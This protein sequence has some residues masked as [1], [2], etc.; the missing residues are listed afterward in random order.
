MVS[1]IRTWLSL[2]FTLKA[3]LILS[4]TALLL[5]FVAVSAFNRSQMN[6]IHQQVLHQ[7]AEMNKQRLALELKIK[8]NEIDAVKSGYIISKDEKLIG[9]FEQK[10]ADFYTLV[11]QIASSASNSDQRKWSAKLTNTSTEYTATFNTALQIVRNPNLSPVE[12]NEQLAKVHELS[13]VHK[14]YIFELVDQFNQ[15]YES[16]VQAAI[17]SSNE[18]VKQ[19]QNTSLIAVLLVLVVSAGVAFLLIRS[20]MRPISRLQKAVRQIAQGDLTSRINNTSRDEL[21]NLSRDFDHMI[22]Q[23]RGM[24]QN[25]QRIASSLSTHSSMFREFS[26]STA[27]ANKEIVRAIHEISAGAEQQAQYTELSSTTINELDEQV[28]DIAKFTDTMQR[29][30]REAAINTHTG[31]ESMEELQSAAR[32]SEE[33]LHHVYQAMETLSRSS[34][35]IARIVGTISDISTQTNVLALNA[36]IEAARAGVHGKGFSVIAEEVRLLSGQTNDSSKTIAVIVK[37][38]M[39]Q[40]KE[41]EATL[42]EAKQSFEQQKGKM[43]DSLAAFQEIRQSMDELSS[44]IG[45]IHSRIAAAEDKNNQLVQSIQHVAAIAQETAA[46]VEEVNSSSLQQDAA[47]HQIAREADDILE[48]AQWLF[49][50]INKFK[51]GEAEPSTD[52]DPAAP[53]A[54]AMALEERN[55]GSENRPNAETASGFNPGMDRNDA[56]RE[57]QRTTVN[58]QE[59]EKAEGQEKSEEEKKK[60]VTV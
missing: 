31:S 56:L 22:G 23:V 39:T 41:L 5:I 16:D 29:K 55:G 47:I 14:E 51:I 49:T 46:G 21:G 57:P 36:A 4:F 25:S 27:L 17:S 48:L 15:A 1:S 45:Q 24:L 50:E 44:H 30:S 40:I 20:F 60:L 38:L 8:T 53:E 35:Q 33:V 7:N 11:E 28:R 19:S 42:G 12:M 32:H 34:A 10:S 58:T 6:G 13:Q 59:A 54:Q 9:Q 3:K 43:S 26:G 18:Y 37:S 52:G 2:E